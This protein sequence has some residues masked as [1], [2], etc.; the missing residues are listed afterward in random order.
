M[1]LRR[2]TTRFMLGVLAVALLA[3]CAELP[4]APPSVA[5]PV[6]APPAPADPGTATPSPA[7]TPSPTATAPR[8]PSD[9]VAGELVMRVD[10]ETGDYSQVDQRQY[11]SQQCSKSADYLDN[12]LYQIVSDQVGEGRYALRH[13]LRPCD[14]RSEIVVQDPH[15]QAD[16]TYRISWM[17]MKPDDFN[18]D[19]ERSALVQQTGVSGSAA[20]TAAGI[21]NDCG[22]PHSSTMRLFDDRLYYR[23]RFPD[24]RQG[25]RTVLGCRDFEMPPL[26]DNQWTDFEMRLRYS[27]ADDGFLQVFQDG[28]LV[29]DFEGALLW[30]GHEKPSDWKI[31]A[32]TGDP[33]NGEIIMYTDALVVERLP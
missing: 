24:G 14:E 31:G 19:G 26:V 28:K 15:L 18:P 5:D 32:Y 4:A 9:D 6:V 3:A 7:G 20:E 29:V 23:V 25:N 16:T 21:V 11:Q 22:N 2:P 8:S 27:M 33:Q 12:S 13:H 10:Y 1:R 17:V 30:E